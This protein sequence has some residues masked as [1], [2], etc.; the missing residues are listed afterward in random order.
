MRFRPALP[1]SR[2]QRHG[3]QQPSVSGQVQR[4]VGPLVVVAVGQVHVFRTLHQE[5]IH[6]DLRFAEPRGRHRHHREIP[7]PG[8]RPAPLPHDFLQRAAHG[9]AIHALARQHA[10]GDEHRR[11]VA[12]PLGE[13]LRTVLVRQVDAVLGRQRREIPAHLLPCRLRRQAQPPAPALRQFQPVRPIGQ[14]EGGIPGLP[15]RMILLRRNHRRPQHIAPP[16]RV[17]M[18]VRRHEMGGLEHQWRVDLQDLAP[19]HGLEAE[20]GQ[21]DRMRLLPDQ[22]RADRRGRVAA[23]RPHHLGPA[24]TLVALAPRLRKRHGQDLPI[25][26]HAFPEQRGPSPQREMRGVPPVHLE[27][28]LAVPTVAGEPGLLRR[29]RAG[30][31]DRGQVLRQ[32][33]APLELLRARVLAALQIDGGAALPEAAPVALAGQERLGWRSP[34]QSH[35]L[36]RELTH[37]A[38]LAPPP[39]VEQVR[40]GLLHLGLAMRN[41]AHIVAVIVQLAAKTE[42]AG[43]AAHDHG[44]VRPDARPVRRVHPRRS[45]REVEQDRQRLPRFNLHRQ[46]VQR[47]MAAGPHRNRLSFHAEGTGQDSGPQIQGLTGFRDVRPVQPQPDPAQVQPVRVLA[48]PVE[49]FLLPFRLGRVA[50]LPAV[51]V[52]HRQAQ[53]GRFESLGNWKA[54]PAPLR[55]SAQGN[56]ALVRLGKRLQPGQVR[57]EREFAVAHRERRAGVELRQGGVVPL[58]QPLAV[59]GFL[60]PATRQRSG[61]Q[62]KRRILEEPPPAMHSL[63]HYLPA[64]SWKSTF[65]PS[66]SRAD[67]SRSTS[68][69]DV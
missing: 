40:P 54:V 48:K 43:L 38:E 36:G 14:L 24:R 5:R 4:Q 13:G 41:D 58:H 22:Q 6:G 35:T 47:R 50:H 26:E 60:G 9:F 53:S 64:G 45:V 34:R 7:A 31:L 10:Q 21:T 46:Q 23:L 49:Q 8:I 19:R 16:R 52:V 61:G 69:R 32:H 20:L 44:L 63:D 29:P 11:M 65:C 68:A 28:E 37:P 1:A 66:F 17:P 57:G 67:R 59:D 62:A 51:G 27:V 42:L 33:H 39:K 55:L 56:A 15:R 25:P 12:V 30:A 2:H 18:R 3:R